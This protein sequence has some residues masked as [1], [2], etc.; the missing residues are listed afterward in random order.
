MIA[1]PPEWGSGSGLWNNA[2]VPKQTESEVQAA[3]RACS[4]QSRRFAKHLIY[5]DTRGPRD[6]DGFHNPEYPAG[7]R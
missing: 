4:P 3:R 5:A 6:S 2:L 7:D 1:G